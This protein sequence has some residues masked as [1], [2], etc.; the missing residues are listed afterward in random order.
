MFQQP[1]CELWCSSLFI[2]N[3]GLKGIQ[4]S[5]NIPE[6]DPSADQTEVIYLLP[7]KFG[8]VRNFN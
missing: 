4:V 8:Y 6:F 7:E 2:L 3:K 1:F 5:V